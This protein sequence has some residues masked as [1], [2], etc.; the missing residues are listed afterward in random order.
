MTEKRKVPKF[1]ANLTLLFTEEPFLDRFAQAQTSGFHAVEC[2]FPYAHPPQDIAEKL[3]KHQLELALFNLPPGNWSH[4][5][6]GLAAL[7]DREQEFR[8][9]VELALKYALELRCKKVHVMAGIVESCFS[10]QQHIATFIK[11][12]RYAAD[13]FSPYGIDVMIEPLNSRDMPGYLISHQ[14]EA[15]ELI[16]QIDRQNVKLQFDIYHAQI[17][18]GDITTLLRRCA[19]HIGHVQIA[20]VP[21]RNEPNLGE[22]NLPYLLDVL[23]EVGYHGWIGCEY[24]PKTNSYDGLDWLKRYHC[25]K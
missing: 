15:V 23:D 16:N 5:E 25:P 4:G 9:S 24:R 3:E 6:R 18:D 2:L 8:N 12:L 11:N 10:R 7:P 19:R 20:S 1:A 22:L 17:M 13:A 21:D 14:K